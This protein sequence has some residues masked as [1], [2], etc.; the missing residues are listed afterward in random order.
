MHNHPA[1]LRGCQ[2]QSIAFV[3]GTILTQPPPGPSACPACTHRAPRPGVA[4]GLAKAPRSA[5]QRGFPLSSPAAESVLLQ[6]GGAVPPHRR[7]PPKTPAPVARP[8]AVLASHA[9]GT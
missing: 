2:D 5:A 1:L 9:P 7:S 8:F 6:N 3:A 4:A